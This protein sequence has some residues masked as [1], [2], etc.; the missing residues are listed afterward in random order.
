MRGR[1]N[2]DAQEAARR[3]AE[4]VDALLSRVVGADYEDQF[5]DY[6][7]DQRV[8]LLVRTSIQV[9]ENGGLEALFE[10][11]MPNDEAYRQTLCA[12]DRIG[13]LAG[14]AVLREALARMPG[15]AAPLDATQSAAAYGTIPEEIRNRLE[16]A[17]F[18][19][20]PDILR[21]LVEFIRRQ[22]IDS[23]ENV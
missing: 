9:V 10:R 21:C 1:L 23:A 8:V 3:N 16:D 12:Y 2:M 7:E 18:E 4:T 11:P 14:A 20:I 6:S 22:S 5:G 13:C 19:S 17:F 15:A